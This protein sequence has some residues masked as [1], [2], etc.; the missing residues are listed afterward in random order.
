MRTI[1]VETLDS[2]SILADEIFCEIMDEKD[3]IDRSRLELECMSRARELGKLTEFKKLLS[4]YKKKEKEYLKAES[5]KKIGNDSFEHYTDFSIPED[6]GFDNLFCGTWIAT[7]HGIQTYGFMGQPILACYH[8]I[9]PVKR[10]ENAETGK[11]KIELA[12]RKGFKWKKIVVEKN[13]IAS[14]SKIVSLSDYGI[15][16]T[17]ENAKALVRYLADIENLNVN[18][19]PVQI[20]TSKLGWINGQFMPYGSD[21]IFDNESKFK[22][23]FDSINPS[24]SREMWYKTA[25]KIRSSG[26]F[27]PNI[28]LI[29]SFASVLIEGLNALPFILNLW[30]D[31]GR[32]KTVALMFATSVWATPKDN[33]YITSPKST[34]TALELRLDFL[35]NL[36]MMIDDMAQIASKFGNDYTELV[37]M[38]CSGAGKDR[39]N[40]TLGLN[41]STSWRNVIITNAEHSLITETMQG[42]AVNRV[43]DVEADEGN[44]FKSGN[45]VA[46]SVKQNYGWAGFDFIQVL[47]SIGTDRIKKI[48]N[49]FKDKLNNAAHGQGVE[50]EEKQVLPMSILL[51]TDKIVTDYL[52]KDEMYLDFDRCLSILKNKGE[53]S[54]NQRAYDFI[55]SEVEINVNRFNP[56]QYGDYHG[57]CWGCIDAGYA[58]IIN[59]IFSRMAEKGN[60]NKKSFL[61]WAEKQG[62]LLTSGSSQTKTKKMKNGSA[63]RCVFLKLDH[64]SEYE[65]IKDLLDESD[66]PFPVE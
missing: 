58:V 45:E 2:V 12:F 31:S 13:Q 23:A 54:E 20:S 63:P 62:L 37:Y 26:R 4:A 35:N 14:S 65:S 25:K 18:M 36:P 27:E 33:D 42:G 39:A 47:Q 24:G 49:D 43:I 15:S 40:A 28:M 51:T 17:S 3:E 46:T 1:N 8:P 66:V 19:I 57:E 5:E 55:M 56:D 11:E 50:K 60:F 30:G 64:G 22:T 52:F 29:A 48:Q 59:N 61:N 21:I 9:L 38:L 32:G 16:V 44:F 6:A 7:D 10:M 53:V 41:K 34:V